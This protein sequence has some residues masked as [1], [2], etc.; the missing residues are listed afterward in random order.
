MGC[1]NPK[2]A[3]RD[4]SPQGLISG[5]LS[6]ASCNRRD[7]R[8]VG[9]A[10][11]A[12]LLPRAHSVARKP[13]LSR[14]VSK[15]GAS[16]AARYGGYEERGRV[17]VPEGTPRDR[18][19]ESPVD[20]RASRAAAERGWE[21][22]AIEAPAAAWPGEEVLPSGHPRGKAWGGCGQRAGLFINLKSA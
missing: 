14:P 21:A 3:R 15:R 1:V 4:A 6:E 10:P 19:R 5:H 20:R 18:V 7:G 2:G 9:R 11:P 13:G 8:E 16:G 22:R 12:R 17:G